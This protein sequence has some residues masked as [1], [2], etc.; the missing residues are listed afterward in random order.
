M[1]E[2]ERREEGGQISSSGRTWGR[3]GGERTS[4]LFPPNAH[5]LPSLRA[6]SLSN[7]NLQPSHTKQ[8]G[9]MATR[10][11]SYSSDGELPSCLYKQ[12]SLTGGPFRFPFPARPVGDSEALY[13]FRLLEALR[14][15]DI[16][17]IHPFLNDLT[18]PGADEEAAG[19]LLSRAIKCASC[20]SSS[21]L[22][23]SL[24]PRPENE[25]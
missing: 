9:G 11:A 23:F 7:S 13:Q 3:G 20:E 2:G 12:R 25:S 18:K 14:S 19:A 5:L 17:K 8:Q 22:P 21:F 24:S 15:G 10:K 6:P 4:S 16:A 1:V